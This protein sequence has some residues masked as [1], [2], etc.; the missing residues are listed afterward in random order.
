MSSA[1]PT[2]WDVAATPSVPASDLTITRQIA[3]I[4]AGGHGMETADIVRAVSAL[5]DGVQLFGIADDGSP[6]RELIARMGFR[7]LGSA[8]DV[9]ERPDVELLL[10]IGD[11]AVRARLDATSPDR[12]SAP[13]VHPTATVGSFCKLSPGVVLAQGTIITT[14]VHLGRHTHVN[15]GASVSHDCRVG[16]HVTICPGVRVTG[17]ATIGD[18]AFI[19]TSASILPGVS[20]GE[21]AVIGAGAVVCRDVPSGSTVRGVPAR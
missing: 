2:R 17:G 7:F 16:D 11:P 9:L 6:D 14:N 18:R 19:G 20:V 13:V 15:V 12:A 10:G 4:G 1:A 21:D 5:D 8:G 3:V